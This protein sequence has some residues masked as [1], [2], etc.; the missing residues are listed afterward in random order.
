MAA[1]AVAV[2]RVNDLL[3]DADLVELTGYEQPASQARVL[4]EL[5]LNPVIRKDGHVRVTWTALSRAMLIGGQNDAT[6]NFDALRQ[7]G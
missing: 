2:P 3:S 1:E 7:T 6:P 4:R 5:G